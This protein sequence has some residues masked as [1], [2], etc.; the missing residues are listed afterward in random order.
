MGIYSLSNEK[1]SALTE[2]RYEKEKHLQTIIA[3]NPSLLLRSEDDPE[4]ML[5]MRETPIA[6]NSDNNNAFS[7]DHLF[8]DKEGIPVL[9]EVKR[10]TDTRIR[11]EVVAQMI[12]YAARISLSY[13]SVLRKSFEE[14]N[15]KAHECNT[16]KFWNTVSS[17]L[18]SNKFRLV[19]AADKIPDSLAMLVKFLDRNMQNINVYAV[20]I[21]RFENNNSSFLTTKIIGNSEFIKT[22]LD[23]RNPIEWDKDSYNDYLRKSAFRHLDNI[24][25]RIIAF[26]GS[27]EFDCWYGKGNS[28]PT[29]N[30]KYKG[31]PLFHLMIPENGYFVE[32]QTSLISKKLNF[33]IS[34]SEI[35]E[36]LLHGLDISDKNIRITEEHIR[37]NLNLFE[38]DTYF[39]E[40][41]ENSNKMKEYILNHIK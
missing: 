39:K 21:T 24:S 33:A 36:I 29:F 37:I 4:L 26:L 40:F 31:I 12:D 38:N 34:N 1:A 25:N 18:S 23:P 10:S 11:R 32:I 19:F 17:N 14:I 3:K 6:E 13:V 20:E 16:D 28:H 22:K 41:Q 15:G 27:S 5:V 9:C 35:K 2:I 30:A 8:V 7:L